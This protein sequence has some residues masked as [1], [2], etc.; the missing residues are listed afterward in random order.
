MGNK[1]TL[2]AAEDDTEV[3]RK[4]ASKRDVSPAQKQLLGGVDLA[5]CKYC[6]AA[7]DL[8]RVFMH[9]TKDYHC[10]YCAECW[11]MWERSCKWQPAVRIRSR[12]P[13]GPIGL[14]DVFC[15]P[16]FICAQ[17]D[18]TFFDILN[19][20][21]GV[22]WHSGRHLKA[23]E[24]HPL[25]QEIVGRLEVGFRVNGSASRVNLY[26]E[27]DGKP[28]HCDASGGERVTVGVAF[29]SPRD[30]VISHIQTGQTVSFEMRNG[31][32]FAFT[33]E[34]NAK[35]MHGVPKGPSSRVSVIVWGP[36]MEKLN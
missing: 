31:D 14:Q 1:L 22:E 9:P 35:F 23:D 34:V 18:F 15:V 36:R 4:S 27:G 33:P 21:D 29:G 17:N 25:V 11:Y 7:P 16:E 13:E 6:G 20:L 24:S 30:V 19:K 28:L 2:W 32:V 5:Q 8:A 26:R 10:T 3:L 12:P